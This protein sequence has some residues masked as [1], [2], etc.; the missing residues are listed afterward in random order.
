MVHPLPLRRCPS[1]DTVQQVWERMWTLFLPRHQ[2]ELVGLLQQVTAACRR[3]LAQVSLLYV[4][5]SAFITS[6]HCARACRSMAWP[7]RG[8]HSSAT[9]HCALDRGKTTG[10][11]CTGPPPLT[12][13]YPP[14]T[15][16]PTLAPPTAVCPRSGLR[17]TSAWLPSCLKLPSS[18]A[19]NRQHGGQ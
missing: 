12:Q 16:I 11:C 17:A 3:S 19:Q 15:T 7:R 1:P 8:T 10:D 14:L 5:L 9:R 18:L 4:C 2:L 6:M 13:W